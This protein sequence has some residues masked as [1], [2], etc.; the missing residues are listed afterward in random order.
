MT[1]LWG[2]GSLSLVKHL[3][4]YQ[5]EVKWG[6]SACPVALAVCAMLKWK[7]NCISTKLMSVSFPLHEK[8]CLL[9]LTTVLLSHFFLVSMQTFDAVGEWCHFWSIVLKNES[10]CLE[11]IMFYYTEP[12]YF[13]PHCALQLARA[14]FIDNEILTLQGHLSYSIFC[15]CRHL[16]ALILSELYRSCLRKDG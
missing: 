12:S 3:V 14:V 9:D 15:Q 2:L 11:K 7:H 4:I 8:D 1:K 16:R 13:S 6:K 5:M 10:V